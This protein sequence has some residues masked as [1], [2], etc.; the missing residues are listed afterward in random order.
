MSPKP[1]HN[2]PTSWRANMRSLSRFINTARSLSLALSVA[3]SREDFRF[4]IVCSTSCRHGIKYLL[5]HSKK[6]RRQQQLAATRSMANGNAINVGQ[7]DADASCGCPCASCQCNVRCAL[8]VCV[9]LSVCGCL[10]GVSDIYSQQF[11]AYFSIVFNWQRAEF[12]GPHMQRDYYGRTKAGCCRHS[13]RE[14]AQAG[15]DSY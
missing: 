9:C 1:G 4:I 3:L 11:F 15:R 14:A 2:S 7:F 10:C 5:H 13:G 12:T 8:S 6:R